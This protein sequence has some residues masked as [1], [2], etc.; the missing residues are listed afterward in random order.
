VT[1]TALQLHGLARLYF[2]ARTSI[3]V[4]LAIKVWPKRR[5]GT[6]A[7]LALLYVRSSPTPTDPIAKISFGTARIYG[8]AMIQL[9][10][11]GGVAPTGVGFGGVPCNQA[12]LAPYQLQIPIAELYNDVPGGAPQGVP[13]LPI[14]LFR[15]QQVALRYL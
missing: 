12:G 6:V 9:Q 14:D 15:V 13:D 7:M 1:E 11:I 10:N 8:N 3:R 2:S 5:N 4:Y